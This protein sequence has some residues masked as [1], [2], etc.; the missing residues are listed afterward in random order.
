LIA[1][2]TPRLSEEDVTVEFTKVVPM[3]HRER[4]PA[5]AAGPAWLKREVVLALAA[6]CAVL[7]VGLIVLAI[8][9][10]GLK[11]QI[12]QAR[13]AAA[14]APRGAAGR[15]GAALTDLLKPGLP[16]AKAKLGPRVDD[17]RRLGAG[18]A[19]GAIHPS[20]LAEALSDAPDE[21]LAAVLNA[22]PERLAGQVRS[23]LA[24]LSRPLPS[25]LRPTQLRSDLG[26]IAA[27][28]WVARAFPHAGKGRD[29]GAQASREAAWLARAGADEIELVAREIGIRAVARAFSG[30]SRE[31]L[32][33]LC[34]GL[35]ANDSVRLVSAVVELRDQTKPED[36][37][38]LQRQ[39][40]KLLKAG[41][42]SPE[43][44][45]DTGLAML[46]EAIMARLGERARAAIAWRL[47]E[48]LG[49]RLFELSA[50]GA[51]L[52]EATRAA[53]AAELPGWMA[54]LAKKGAAER[55]G[56]AGGPES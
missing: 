38:V 13:Q 27:E 53:F 8:N 19:L 29:A 7:A 5:L 35:P 41:G 40:L 22:L 44:F 39:H 12:A 16:A 6:G 50:P 55:Y 42:V 15:I 36:L 25:A 4:D 31:D 30:I 20:W 54:E 21:T 46:A 17:L 18:A 24:R 37:R 23:G 43:L 32:L 34:H 14:K 1:H 45:A 33:K 2:S 56:G 28:R 3:P 48:P 47:P 11:K 52:D 9:I 10:M 26:R 49:R 51:V